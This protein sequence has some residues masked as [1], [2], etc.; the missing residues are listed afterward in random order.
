MSALEGGA[1]LGGQSG[2][3]MGGGVTPVP[4][5]NNLTGQH[6]ATVEV[7][8]GDYESLNSLGPWSLVNGYAAV[9]RVCVGQL[10]RRDGIGPDDCFRCE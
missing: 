8:A 7:A 4:T 10:S 1:L 6:I 9:G 3:G 2:N 5:L